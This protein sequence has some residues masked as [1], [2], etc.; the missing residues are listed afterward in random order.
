MLFENPNK[1]KKV[2]THH[3][4]FTLGEVMVALIIMGVAIAATIGITK[5]KDTFVNR[6]M[7]YSAFMNLKGGISSLIDEGC[8]NGEVPPA[9]LCDG[10][11]QLPKLA[12]T[13]SN[14]GLCDRLSRLYNTIGT[15]S[16]SS[17]PTG[18]NNSSS[19]A[20]ATMMA[21][22]IFTLSNSQIY[23][24][25]TGSDT[26]GNTPY[27]IYIDID[28]PERSGNLG[29]DVFPFFVN[30]TDGTV[31]PYYSSSNAGPSL[32]A[33]STDFLSATVRYRSGS[34]YTILETGVP[35]RQALCDAYGQYSSDT[36]TCAKQANCNTHACEVLI[37]KPGH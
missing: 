30:S 37:N 13:A 23:Y 2:T 26:S 33:T 35:Y 7:Y 4:G 28:G 34:V 16:C 6:Y 31:V 18:S 8:S 29:V 15:N 14:R 21:S 20:F 19:L 9:T 25:F 1:E 5:S 10:Y 32:G 17:L 22:P 12:H 36:D 27:I 24:G 3:F 11:K